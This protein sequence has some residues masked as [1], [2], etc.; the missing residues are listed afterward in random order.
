[1]P[2][3]VEDDVEEEYNMLGDIEHML[4][5]PDTL[6]G[7]VEFEDYNFWFPTDDT[8]FV[9]Q[10]VRFSPG[11]Y[12]IIDEILVNA[13]DQWVRLREKT[14]IALKKNTITLNDMKSVEIEPVTDIRINIEPENNFISVFNDGDG[15][16]V[17]IHNK[18]KMYVPEMIFGHLRSSGN[19]NKSK[20]GIKTVGG[21]NGYGAKLANIFSDKF[22]IDTVDKNTGLRFTQEYEKNMTVKSDPVIKKTKKTPYTNISFYPILNR[23]G[24]EDGMDDTIIK[25]VQKRAFDLSACT[26]ESVNVYF[27]DNLID[28]HN[29]EDYVN[30]YIGEAYPRVHSKINDRWEIVA[31]LSPNQKFDQVSFVNG[32]STIRGGKH[33]DY[34]ATQIVNKMKAYIQS[35]KKITTIKS[36]H[37]KDNLMLFVKCSI[38]DATFDTQTKEALT[39][40]PS[41]FGSTAVISDVFINKL[42]TNC[43]LMDQVIQWHE[44]KTSLSLKKTD[45]TRRCNLCIPKLDDADWAGS[46][47]N[48]QKACL[49]LTEGDSA[50]T[51]ALAGRS[52]VLDDKGNKIGHKMYGVFPLRGKV[53]N[54]DGASA[55]KILENKE[56]TYLKQ[57]LGLQE[58]KVYKDTK[59]LRYGSILTMC[60]Q[61]EDG[62]HIKGLIMNLFKTKWPSLFEMKGFITSL[63][64]PV[65]KAT[66]GK[67]VK[68]FYTIPE[69]EKWLDKNKNGKGWDIK[70][71]KGLATSTPKEGREYFEKEL[72]TIYEVKNKEED[73]NYID[74]AFSKTRQPDRKLWLADYDRNNIPDYTASTVSY[75]DFVNKELIHFS[76]SDNRRSIPSLMDGL[77]E[78]QRKI[79]F[80]TKKKGKIPDSGIKVVQLA[81]YIG[82]HTSYH[83]GDT[84]LTGTIYGMAHNFMGSNNINLLKPI[85]MFGSRLQGGKDSGAPRYTFTRLENIANS[86][87]NKLD[88]PLY[89]YLEDDGLSIEPEYYVPVIP[90][91]LVNGTK[92][93]GTGYSS[94]IP[95]FNPIEV[96]NAVKN[97][98]NGN[99]ISELMPWYRGF[100]GYINKCGNTSYISH[101][102]YKLINSNTVEISE[103][104]IGTWTKPYKTFLDQLAGERIEVKSKSPKT[105]KKTGQKP[106]KILRKIVEAHTDTTVHFTLHFEDGM[107]DKILE[108][109]VDKRGISYFEKLFKLTSSLSINNMVLYNQDDKLQKYNSTTEI[110]ESFMVTREEFYVRR[111]EYLLNKLWDTKERM[112]WKA[113]FIMS[114]ISTDDDERIYI[115][116]RTKVNI[117]Q[118]LETKQFPKDIGGK[119]TPLEE[120]ETVDEDDNT[121]GYNYLLMMQI[122]SLTK[123]KID[124]LLKE[125][126]EI[127]AEYNSIKEKTPT[128]LW[129]EDLEELENQYKLFNKE[130]WKSQG[131]AHEQK[132]NETVQKKKKRQ[133]MKSKMK[134]NYLDD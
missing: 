84:S 75:K 129:L 81:G 10:D 112:T 85:G 31:C 121:K 88:E 8:K 97:K 44:M 76:N 101:G 73:Y 74:L 118:Q 14:K 19:Y 48:S 116:K 52:A 104:P 51:L 93:I 62:F 133:N 17:Q 34:I 111:R 72:K 64:T 79:L 70:F 3:K 105:T 39:L 109:P 55:E 86:L 63:V 26:D 124:D 114:V 128:D 4:K 37:V 123:E 12:K 113:K 24:Y 77:K 50:S 100:T 117:Y 90:T 134:A 95:C 29:F 47:R 67:S 132:Y 83:H 40:T 13:Y 23:F 60:D 91:I 46:G 130:F 20:S 98:I 82:E 49:I 32:V 43:G 54:V 45:G 9:K 119:L 78:S 69:H 38:D 107:L 22:I 25:L 66:K 120:L 42:A 53:L 15:I 28:C 126:D 131:K 11:L 35:K 96:I 99:P 65:V 30:K 103:L 33:V 16:P 58:G 18:F 6:I 108:A 110:I 68:S 7:S 36:E 122:Y 21:R 61:D 1:M 125:R 102:V 41:K 59:S 57:I 89:K 87:F 80:G 2:N 94:T 115:N 27:N 92:G 56:I 71:Y 5:F 127:L 106:P